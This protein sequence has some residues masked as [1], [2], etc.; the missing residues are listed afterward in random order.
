MEL[1]VNEVENKEIVLKTSSSVENYDN[2]VA[3]VIP[4]PGIITVYSDLTGL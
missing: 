2:F 4:G 1:V 3:S